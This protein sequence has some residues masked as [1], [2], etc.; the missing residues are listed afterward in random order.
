MLKGFTKSLLVA[1]ITILTAAGVQAEVYEMRTYTTHE[2]KL[3][4]LHAR[5]KDHTIQLFEKHGM[6]NVA[7]WVPVD[8][9]NTLIYIIA[10]KDRESA[11][12]NWRAF[13]SDPQWQAVAKASNANGP[14]LAGIEN[15][16]MTKTEY[17]PT[18]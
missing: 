11:Q 5:F 3:P 14:I 4:D 15:V 17:S 12:N 13:G 6:R 10:H 1:A 7:Y 16:F 18:N 2:G 8:T 9:P